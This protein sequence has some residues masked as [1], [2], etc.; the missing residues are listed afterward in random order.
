V[1]HY[2]RE[3][4]DLMRTPFPESHTE[5]TVFPGANRNRVPH[6]GTSQ[7]RAQLSSGMKTP[8]STPL[9]WDRFFYCIV[10][11]PWLPHNE[12]KDLHSWKFGPLPRHNPHLEH[13]APRS[14]VKIRPRTDVSVEDANNLTLCIVYAQIP[15][16]ATPTSSRMDQSHPP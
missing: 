4:N 3:I 12:Q 8:L 15:R 13:S 11:L 14:G 6:R 7:L 2:N 10:H 16:L 9:G 5:K 1:I